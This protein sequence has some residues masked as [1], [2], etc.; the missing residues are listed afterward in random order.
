MEDLY[1]AV[2]SYPSRYRAKDLCPIVLS[3]ELTS[4]HRITAGDPANLL[5]RETATF[6]L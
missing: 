1:K 4:N 6:A 3:A 5:E 2:M